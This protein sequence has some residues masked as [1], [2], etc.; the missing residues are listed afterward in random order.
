MGAEHLDLKGNQQRAVDSRGLD[1]V[2]TAGA[3]SGK[4]R[5]LVQRYLA[6][7]EEGIALR[8]ILAITF[9]EKAAREMRNRIRDS[10]Q[11][12][13]QAGEKENFWRELEAGMDAARIGTIHSLC[14]EI[15]RAHPSAAAVD[16]EFEVV[17]EGIAAVLRAQAVADALAWASED[18]QAARLFASF[19]AGGLERVLSLLMARRL[20]ASA[21][22]DSK[23]EVQSV[24]LAA[25]EGYIQ[26][27]EVV[28]AIEQLERL[29]DAGDLLED[30]GEKLEAQLLSFLDLWTEL[31]E[32]LDAND[33]VR[34]STH[35]YLLRREHMNLTAGKKAS[36]AKEWL[37]TFR[38][39]YDAN[40]NPWLGG[41]KAS[42]QMP[43]DTV[44]ARFIEDLQRLTPLFHRAIDA[45]RSSL[46]ARRALDFDDLEDKALQLLSDA[47][48]RE[49][50]QAQIAQLLVDEFQDTNERQRQI[51]EALRGE[52]S[53]RLFV[54]GDARQSIYR[55]R[56]ADVTVFRQVADDIQAR[57]GEAIELELTFRGHPELLGLLDRLLPP[58]MGE[59][60]D[61]DRLF[62][63][64]YTSLQPYRK[65][66]RS[67]VNPPFLEFTFGLGEDAQSARPLAARALVR[68]LLELRA[69]GQI[70]EWDE[71]VL[72][73]RAS[74]GFA[75][76]EDA[77]EVFGVP[78]VTVAG[79]GFYDRPEIRDALN[80][81][82]ALANPWDDL[83]MAGLLR[84]PAFG[85]S[86]SALYTLRKRDGGFRPLNVALASEPEGL[87]EADRANAIRA[88]EI[89]DELGPLVDRL[90][91]AELIKRVVDRTDYRAALASGHHRTWQN[92]DKLRVDAHA[93]GLVRVRTFLEY[94][95]SIRDVGAREGEAPTEAEGAVRLMTIHKAKGLEFPL[96]ALADASRRAQGRS[97]AAYLQTETGLTFK[98]DRL[99]GAP[100]AYRIA[101]AIDREQA[102]AEENRLLYVALTRAQEKLIISGHC[103]EGS[104]GLKAD[105]WMAALAEAAGIDMTEL[106][107]EGDKL[108]ELELE[109]GGL[110][111][112]SLAWEAEGDPQIRALETAGKWPTSR[113]APLYL[114]IETKKG[115]ALDPELDL[116]P[117]R[118]WRATGERVHPP[119]TVIGLM[120]HKALES[121][122]FPGDDG[123]ETL[124]DTT[125]LNQG[126]VE[127]RQ[128]ERAVREVEQL[129]RRFQEDPLYR[130]IAGAAR[131]HHE[132]PYAWQ[133]PQGWTDAGIIDLLY[134]TDEGWELVDFKADELRDEEALTEAIERHTDQIERYAQAAKQLLGTEV[135][136]AL[137][138]LDY[139]GEVK[140]VA[141]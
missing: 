83:A 92:L 100:L 84:S 85:L 2:V 76:Y 88:R 38:G 27:P 139:M 107:Q 115:E 129:L 67:G 63:V 80:I 61:S 45:Y 86:D 101:A 128:R 102:R 22:L 82:R 54:V 87:S 108:R 15:L 43:D 49:T 60:G 34:A 7:L 39:N 133:A 126:L 29:R 112:V 14:A 120:V 70:E 20:D 117:A 3:G 131:R 111:G 13:A 8:Q 59:Q 51:V 47:P 97:E 46:V 121:W 124:L 75:F 134:Q 19:S 104:S 105:G 48:I 50:W 130:E 136:S 73:F 127:T 93:S 9:T 94:I 57:G 109:G 32:G 99:A 21:A 24:L 74:T 30:A 28:T 123:L 66:P 122:L 5:T 64:P 132:I 33:L 98:A 26:A 56:G 17:E 12:R 23:H 125:A 118:V 71:V 77:L 81:L 140:V 103:T 68:R 37:R 62:Q 18:E 110:I 55:F 95:S 58:I 69:E 35:L 53:G 116:E 16:P 6:S 10:V 42:D 52:T 72:L 106:A 135:I 31:A 113:A 11:S 141:V 90:P 25:L 138:F 91:V 89:L 1:V 4:T 44:E 36:Q 65:E 114:P 41:A 78:F 119:A 40:V 79:R 96:V 137:C